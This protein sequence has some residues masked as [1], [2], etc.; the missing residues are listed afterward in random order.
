MLVP[1]AGIEPARCNAPRDFK[2]LASTNFA[3]PAAQASW[4]RSIV[5]SM[6]RLTVDRHPSPTLESKKNPSAG[7]GFFR[8]G[9]EA[10]PRVEL[11]NNDFADRRLT[12]WLC[13]LRVTKDEGSSC[14]CQ[15][16]EPC[17]MELIDI[18]VDI[19]QGDPFGSPWIWS[20]KRDSNPRHPP[21]QGGALPAE[22]FP[23]LEFRERMITPAARVSNRNECQ[24]QS[25]RYNAAVLS[26]AL[27]HEYS[28]RDRILAAFA[29]T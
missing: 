4:G 7:D 19:T 12:T 20:G 21:W 1:R 2:S 15:A 13:R 6:F 22:L 9:L 10:A 16:N 18:K 27:S 23:R 14:T 29:R 11:G 24:Q 17:K 5:L 3:T 25:S 8:T 26:A 28:A